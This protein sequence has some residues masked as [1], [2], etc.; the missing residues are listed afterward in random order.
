MTAANMTPERWRVV[1]DILQRAIV[2]ERDRRDA[3]VGD[4]CGTDETLRGEVVSLLAAHDAT[5]ADFLE[6][7]PADV[8][9]PPTADAPPRGRMVAAKVAVYA[10]AVAALLGLMGG[11]HVRGTVDR[12]TT[13]REPI[14]VAPSPSVNASGASTD[15][16]S[17]VVA[18]RAGRTI[19]TIAADRPWTPR[20]SPNGTQVAYGAFGNGRQTSDLWVTDVNAGTTRRLTDDDGDSNDPQWSPDGTMLAYS[21]NAP[22]GKDVAEQ[23]VGGGAAR[24]VSRPGTQFPSDWT[25]DGVLLV[26]DDAQGDAHDILVQ[27]VD[28]SPARAY[29]STRDDELAARSSPDGRWIAYSSNESGRS[30]V[31]LDSYPR[32][33]RRVMISHGGGADPVWRGDGR[34]LYYWRDGALVAVQLDTRGSAP[35]RPGAQVVLFHAPYE[36]GVNTMYDVSADG[37]RFVIVERGR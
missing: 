30:E 5:P 19:R 9:D 6:K 32:P 33:G 22:G 12:W 16:L 31:Y 27:P 18:D 17:L 29:A 20:F 25:R 26:T 34:E 28:G 2:C 3:F 10:T 24:I 4:A 11:W 13:R 37:E 15:G 23:A 8:F 7:P 21:V 1:D 14:P 35:P 36:G